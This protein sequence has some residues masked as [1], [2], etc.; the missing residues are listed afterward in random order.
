MRLTLLHTN[1]LHG[2]VE[3]IARTATLVERI[4]AESPHR[5]VYVDC[6]DV[7]E[8]TSRLSNLTKGVAMHRLLAAAGCEAAAVGNAVWLRY[9]PQA[10]TAEAAAV[11]YPLLCANLKPIEGVHDGV[12]IDGVGFVGATDTFARFRSEFDFG[13]DAVPVVETVRAVA[14]RLRTEGAELVVLLSH[15]GLDPQYGE[16]TD[17]VL[18]REL[19]GS[20]DLILGA[21]SHHA[22]PDGLRVGNVLIAQAGSHGAWL[23]QVEIEGDERYA[24]LIPVGDD[25]PSHPG[26][27]AEADRAERELDESMDETIAVLAEPLDGRWIAEM[28]RRRMQAEV[29]LAVAGALLDHPLPAGPLRRRELWEVCH[30]AANPG[31]TELTGAQLS[32]MLQR[33]SAPGYEAATP[34]PL[35]GRPRGKLHAAVP[36][37]LDPDR[38]YR[39]AATDV[40]LGSLGGLVDPE[41]RLAVRYDFPTIVREAI[42]A[43]L[44]GR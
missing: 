4:T 17:D 31:V 23:G 41:W 20:V 6:G 14:H 37:A 36:A 39:V 33:G 24:T 35:R 18:A 25:L 11:A 3:G 30:S 8:T 34:R 22:L 9:G 44:L 43:D 19:A 16:E 13:I 38:T 42:E 40:E 12:V 21:H 15:M 27:V 5:V 7:E 10:V 28:L 29:G 32:Q 26:V 2:N 1:D